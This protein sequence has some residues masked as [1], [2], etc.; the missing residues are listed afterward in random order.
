MPK[1]QSEVFCRPP[2]QRMMRI[3]E[4]LQKGRYPNCTILAEEFEVST[5]TA[6][7]DVDFMKCRLNLPIEYEP[8]RNGYRYTAP[9]EHLPAIAITEAEMFALLVAQKAISQYEGT[10]FHRPLAA[11]FRKVTAHLDRRLRYSLGGLDDALSF[12]PF[13]LEDTDLKVFEV[14][15]RALQER[16]E[17]TFFYRNFGAPKR[18]RRRAH[19]YH[20]ACINNLWYLFAFDVDRQGLRTFALTRLTE[21]ETTRQRF[22][23]PKDFDLDHHLRGS[24]HVYA[25]RGDYQVVLDFD[26]WAAESLRGR[27]WHASQTVTERPKGGL[28]LEMRLTSL[29]EVD[30]WVLSWGPHVTVVEPKALAVRLLDMAQDLRRRYTPSGAIRL[31]HG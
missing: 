12:R 19:P 8:A 7:R 4:L 9:V 15:S 30:R 18:Q 1:V 13:A 11:A 29:K 28:R 23:L 14:V 17:L 20:L 21:P 16:R 25:G 2:W 10:P 31:N 22:A 6:K 24:F 5:R 3:H 26:A 27:R